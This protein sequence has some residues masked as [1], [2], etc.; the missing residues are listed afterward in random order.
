MASSPS[1]ITPSQ[2]PSRRPWPVRVLIWLGGLLLALALLMLSLSP[3]V[4][5][6]PPPSSADVTAAHMAFQRI[7]GLSGTGKPQPFLLSWVEARG[8]SLLLGRALDVQRV[9]VVQEPDAATLQASVPVGPL[10]ANVSVSIR[11]TQERFP[12]TSIGIGWLHL[13]PFIVR[14]LAKGARLALN[15]RGAHLAPLDD[16]VRGVAINPVGVQAMLNLPRNTKLFR[17]L[18]DVQSDPVDA[19]LVATTYCAL[20][21]A[22]A[23]SP[24]TD[25]AVQV[26]RAFA[27]PTGLASPEDANRAAFVALA[28]F[29]VSPNV[30][31]LAG[32]AVQRT[33]IC[34]APPQSLMLIGRTDLPKH[35]V[36]SAALTSLFGEN[37]SQEMGTWK[38]ISDSGPQGSGFSFVD[39]SADRSGTHHAKRA[40]A[41]DTAADER[42]RLASITEA[43]LLPVHALAFAEGMSEAEFRSRYTSTESAEYD[44]MVAV[45]DRVLAEQK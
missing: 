21:R 26:Q 13:P 45:I 29:T 9:A 3:A 35:L 27:Q 18:N 44:K 12:D 33:A 28:M 31:N 40:A 1:A 30:G 6:A 36:L 15:L 37:V 20:A 10:W 8:G 22:Q 14:P 34:R 4:E 32:D 19:A 39:L 16:M 5:T 42:R 2:L 25:L 43:Q 41:P 23:A 17:Q 7:R 24:A 38:E 11:N